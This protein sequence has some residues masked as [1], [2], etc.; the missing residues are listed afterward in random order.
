MAVEIFSSKWQKAW[1]QALQASDP[2]KQA[3]K[4]WE[5]AL[6]LNVEPDVRLFL[7]LH[8]GECREIRDAGAEDECKFELAA[9]RA[10][11]LGLLKNGGDPLY[12]LMRG[13]LKL[14]QGSKAKLLP[15]TKAAKLM[16]AAAQDLPGVQ[17]E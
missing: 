5:G 1:Q 13:K 9:P 6:V 7:D 16:L 2:Y 15:Y 3:A 17:Y 8:L 4:T 11:W 14:I 12:L 10:T